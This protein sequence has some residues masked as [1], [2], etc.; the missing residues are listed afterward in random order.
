MALML[1]MMWAW[2]P[3]THTSGHRTGLMYNPPPRSCG[4]WSGEGDAI[5]REPEDLH[6]PEDLVA[7]CSPIVGRGRLGL[8]TLVRVALVETVEAPAWMVGRQC[9][10]VVGGRASLE[11]A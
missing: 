5:P 11:L 7:S 6:W 2:V 3:M 8:M 9:H 4:S 1:Q 10:L